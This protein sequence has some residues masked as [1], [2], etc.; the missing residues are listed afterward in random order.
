M[1]DNTSQSEAI[2]RLNELI[3]NIN[4]AMLTTIDHDGTLRSR[5]MA[6]QQ[7]EPDGTLWFFTGIDTHKVGELKDHDQVNVSYSDAGA[8]SFVSVSG[9]ATISRDKQKIEE[10]W[11]PIN[12]AWF[13]DG[14]E[15][16]NIALIKVDVHAAEY[17]DAPN[18]KMVQVVGFLKALATGQAYDPGEN[19]K[20]NL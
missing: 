19:E 17:W 2:A 1:S 6:T 3:K 18:S 20:I 7:A 14:P 15:D 16:P 11:N 8:N 9:T 12:K 10:L 13:P 4:M 5:P